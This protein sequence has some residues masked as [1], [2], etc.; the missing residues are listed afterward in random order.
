MKKCRHAKEYKGIRQPRCNGGKGCDIC[1]AIFRAKC[2]HPVENLVKEDIPP[3]HTGF[4]LYQTKLTCTR[5]KAHLPY[6]VN[7][8]EVFIFDKMIEL[9]RKIEDLRDDVASLDR[10]VDYLDSNCARLV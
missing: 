4:T 2:T 9:S 5:C 3:D 10:T 1:N 6:H 8:N 7:S